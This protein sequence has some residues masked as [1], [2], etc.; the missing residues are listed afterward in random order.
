MSTDKFPL[1]NPEKDLLLERQ[2]QPITGHQLWELLSLGLSDHLDKVDTEITRDW[3]RK[4]LKIVTGWFKVTNS[5]IE[6]RLLK[7]LTNA[8]LAA[9][10]RA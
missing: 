10:W 6:P 9:G 5:E 1:N 3:Q 7:K 4:L 2:W 8:S